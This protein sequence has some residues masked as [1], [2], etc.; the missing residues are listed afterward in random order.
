MEQKIIHN[1]QI[2]EIDSKVLLGIAFL[3][4]YR[5]LLDIH[6]FILRIGQQLIPCCDNNGGLL[7]INVQNR[8]AIMLPPK[9]EQIVKAQ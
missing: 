5:C 9:S 4:R 6:R 3:K 8:K 1:C 7:I 2:A